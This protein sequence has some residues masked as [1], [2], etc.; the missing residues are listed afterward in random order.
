VPPG[1]DAT[2]PTP[3][4]ILLHGY[5]ASGAQ[6]EMYFKLGPVANAQ[7]FLYAIPDGTVDGAGNRFWNATDAC[8]N[9]FGSAVDDV[10]YLGAIMDDVGTRYNVDPKPIFVVG[11]SNGGFMAHRLAC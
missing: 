10:A 9:Y 2:K 11:H 6:Q 1:Y 8:C 5:T 7:G 3:L 4:L